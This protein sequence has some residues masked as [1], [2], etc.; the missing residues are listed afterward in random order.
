MHISYNTKAEEYLPI[1]GGLHPLKGSMFAFCAF[2]FASW[3]F[4]RLGTVFSVIIR[5]KQ[6][7]KSYG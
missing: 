1:Q 3:G 7:E 2:Y 6:K 4:N 5:K